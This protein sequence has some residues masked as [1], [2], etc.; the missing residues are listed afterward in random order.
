[1]KPRFLLSRC[2]SRAEKVATRCF[3][4]YIFLAG[5]NTKLEKYF[6]LY[7]FTRSQ[8]ALGGKEYMYTYMCTCVCVCVRT[9]QC[10]HKT[11]HYNTS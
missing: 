4:L 2:L 11:T 9:H 7:V 1:M 6:D 10:I 3:Y 5:K 8:Y